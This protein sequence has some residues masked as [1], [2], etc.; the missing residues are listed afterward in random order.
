[1]PSFGNAPTQADV[2]EKATMSPMLWYWQHNPLLF[3]PFRDSLSREPIGTNGDR[4]RQ[5][6]GGG[7]TA[8]PS[9]SLDS[10]RRPVEPSPVPPSG[11]GPLG[12][13]GGLLGLI[14]KYGQLR[15]SIPDEYGNASPATPYQK[16]AATDAGGRGALD[17]PNPDTRRLERIDTTA[18]KKRKSGTYSPPL[19]PNMPVDDDTDLSVA[20][21]DP[22][23]WRRGDPECE[24][25]IADATKT[26][27]DAY[28]K[29]ETLNSSSL[30]DCITGL[31]SPKCGG[32]KVKRAL[33]PEER[34]RILTERVQRM[35]RGEDP[36]DLD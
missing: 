13:V 34:A 28:R 32:T 9:E 4:E 8:I 11:H 30:Q 7:P 20:R 18:G 3:W 19:V 10:A 6:D 1:M 29:G 14:A 33:T 27:I 15:R 36:D 26:C 12:P 17:Q 23:Y 21:G 22:R 2:L 5:I 16:P 35:M 25:E 24:K 31:L